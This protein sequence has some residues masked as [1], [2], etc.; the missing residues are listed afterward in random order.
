MA[1]DETCMSQ[2]RWPVIYLN[3]D[4]DAPAREAVVVL[5]RDPLLYSTFTTLRAQKQDGNRQPPTIYTTRSPYV[6]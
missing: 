2:C 6:Q 4:C 1:A 3:Y 5:V